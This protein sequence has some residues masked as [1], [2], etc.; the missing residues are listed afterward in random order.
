MSRFIFLGIIFF[1]LF[2]PSV[3]SIGICK[4]SS[5]IEQCIN[6]NKSGEPLSIEDFV[7]IQDTNIEKIAYQIVLDK[8]FSS[9]DEEIEKYLVDLEKNKDYYFGKSAISNFFEAINDISNK[10]GK[11]GYYW[12]KYKNYCSVGDENANIN[13]D[14]IQVE[15]ITCLGGSVSVLN[16]KDFFRESNCMG[17]AEL[18]LKLYKDV[19]YD[20]LTL[21][22][23]Y[24]RQDEK[25]LFIQKERT[26][27]DE[28]VELF[29]INI[30]YIERIWRKWPSVTP[31]AK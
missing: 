13:I 26:K 24:V 11:N 10:L 7:C 18:K 8:K 1:L 3:F 16:S 9:L 14:S 4:Y 15:T 22:K 31:V 6:A 23:H 19:A 30:G 28:I 25:K 27:Y 20:I 29:M 17:L 2:I 5:E 21:N 12:E